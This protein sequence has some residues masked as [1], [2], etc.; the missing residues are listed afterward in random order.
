M[1]GI[2]W[3]SSLERPRIP[4]QVSDK[5]A[6]LAAYALLG[7]LVLRAANGGLGRPVSPGAA[8]FSFLL[9]TAYGA[10]D[11]WHQSFVPGRVASL[12]DLL[13]DALGALLAIAFLAACGRRTYHAPVDRSSRTP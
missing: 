8:L 12:E 4:M 9:S 3:L 13:A 2:F 10:S 6:H 5:L 1:A 11:E 7:A